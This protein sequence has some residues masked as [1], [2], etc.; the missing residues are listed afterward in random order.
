M[1]DTVYIVRFGR[2]GEKVDSEH[3]VVVV[4]VPRYLTSE[5][6]PIYAKYLLLGNNW[7]ISHEKILCGISYK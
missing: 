6:T 5:I 2:N 7:V 1:T 3:A 4:V